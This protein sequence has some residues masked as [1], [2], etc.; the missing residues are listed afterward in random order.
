MKTLTLTLG[1]IFS[2]QTFA[3][4]ITLIC[5]DQNSHSVYQLQL[6]EDFLNVRL[7]ALLRDSSTLA[8]GTRDLQMEEGESS[9]EMYT[10][11][12]R[13]NLSLQVALLLNAK[14][15]SMLKSFEV[16]EVTAY[17]QQQKGGNLS[18]HTT[19]LCGNR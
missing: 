1:L 17:Y 15:A 4:D 7:T 16:L 14:K 9:A 11:G 5:N 3:A 12:G 18:G 6:S 2:I 8:A 10:Y 19:L 13:T